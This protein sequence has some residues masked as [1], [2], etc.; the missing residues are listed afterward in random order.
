[1]DTDK[2]EME[3]DQSVD[4]AKENQNPL[5]MKKIG[6]KGASDFH[7]PNFVIPQTPQLPTSP[8]VQEAKKAATPEV[9]L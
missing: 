2:E 4:E 8:A 1:M 5:D 9:Y 7:G 6:E 3:V